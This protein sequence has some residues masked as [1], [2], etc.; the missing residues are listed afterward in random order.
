MSDHDVLF[1]RM[2]ALFQCLPEIAPAQI[3]NW[4]AGDTA[5]PLT[6]AYLTRLERQRLEYRF[7]PGQ[8]LMSP[9]RWQRVMGILAGNL[10]PHLKVKHASGRRPHL[11]VAFCSQDGQFIN[12]HFGQ[13]RLFFIYGFDDQGHWLESLRRYPSAPQEKEANEVRASLLHDCHLLFCEAV[14]GPA[15]A[16]LIRHNIHPMK[17]L[18]GQTLTAQCDD[19]QKLLTGRL[20]PW[21]AKRL[22][23]TNP[24]EAR[25][26]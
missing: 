26:F 17:V 5:E 24:L 25:V 3:L 1:W 23:R 7:P 13:C 19:I 12:G 4:I 18:P 8:A 21:L 10:P 14:G 6:P 16:R 9:A 15:A 20:P 2:F 11:L 22:A